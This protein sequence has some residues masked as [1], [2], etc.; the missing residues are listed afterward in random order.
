MTINDKRG[1]TGLPEYGCFRVTGPDAGSFL[2]GQLSS[3]IS[4]LSSRGGQLSSFNDPKGRVIAVLRL[5]RLDDEYVAVAPHAVI[6]T[7]ARRLGMFV[8]RARVSV[9]ICRDLTVWG[10]V[11]VPGVDS[12]GA[13]ADAMLL[14]PKVNAVALGIR[15]LSDTPAA[16]L[17]GAVDPVD[18][19]SAEILAGIP[20]IY[21]CTAG[22]FVAQMLHLDRLGAVSFDKGCYV[23]QEVIA[24]AHHL[25]RVK[26]HARLFRLATGVA[27]PGDKVIVDDANAGT[28]LRVA[29]GP[30]RSLVMAVIRDGVSGDASVH[31]YNL[32]PLPDPF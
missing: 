8:L 13:V 28:V 22:S 1:V 26:R 14:P 31:G 32:E 19:E 21:P 12:L 11:G 10:A 27:K 5:L 7:T 18:W 23:G 16:A 9:N 3:D 25:G 17:S 29:A 24:R 6:E 30:G 20:E 4:T 15:P 2:Q